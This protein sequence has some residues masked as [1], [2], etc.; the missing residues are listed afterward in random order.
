MAIGHGLLVLHTVLL[1][2]HSHHQVGDG[3]ELRHK[4]ANH[5]EQMKGV[6]LFER[7][8]VLGKAQAVVDIEKA[9]DVHLDPM[10]HCNLLIEVSTGTPIAMCCTN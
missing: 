8:G 9:Q 10:Y 2:I 4:R 6:A 1:S 7:D 3:H 5:E